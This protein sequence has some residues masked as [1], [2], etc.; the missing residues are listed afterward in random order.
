YGVIFDNP[1]AGTIFEYNTISGFDTGV[2]GQNIVNGLTLQ[3]NNIDAVN[4]YVQ[5]NSTP[6]QAGTCGGVVS[7]TSIDA[8]INTW[9][10]YPVSDAP[11]GKIYKNPGNI[12]YSNSGITVTSPNGG[13]DWEEYSHHNITWDQFSDPGNPTTMVDLY[14]SV[15]DGGSWVSIENDLSRPGTGSMTYDWTIPDVA[16][17]ALALIRVDLNNSSGTVIGLDQSNDNFTISEF[18]GTFPPQQQSAGTTVTASVPSTLTFTISPVSSGQTVNAATTTIN[19]DSTNVNFGTFSGSAT[20][21]GA[22]DLTVHTNATDGFVVTLQASGNLASA[23]DYISY[24][25]GTNTAPTTWIS[26]PGSGTE[27]Y[28]GYTTDDSTL[29]TGTPARFIA[30]KWAGPSTSPFEILYHND[31]TDGS[32][33]GTGA[34]RLG[35]QLELTGLQSAG[36]YSTDLI[37][38]C[39]ATY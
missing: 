4:Y 18:S 14:Y 27:G 22:H 29:G 32:D 23:A 31:V 15:N 37:L 28:W 16:P 12:W 34:T 38:I 36:V 21:I 11:A 17:T 24:F 10:A 5:N 2:L 7:G 8:C 35:Y 6:F 20:S 25:T 1:P 26:P 19:T 33:T 9:G 30:N 39:T 13:E 3:Y